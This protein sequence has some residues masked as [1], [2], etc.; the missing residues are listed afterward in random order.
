MGGVGLGC[1]SDV[2]GGLLGGGSTYGPEVLV[3]PLAHI[4]SFHPAVE[5]GTSRSSSSSLLLAPL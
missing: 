5:P 4:G 3:L 1:F 2:L